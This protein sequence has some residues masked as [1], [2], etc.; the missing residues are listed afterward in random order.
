MKNIIKTKVV[1]ISFHQDVVS[2]ISPGDELFLVREDNWH[3]PNAI[4]VL[5][6]SKKQL[7]YVRRT[8]AFDVAKAMNEGVAVKCFALMI[9]GKGFSL[10]GINI[11]IQVGVSA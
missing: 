6:K 5:S 3:D 7:G 11:E 2:E 4:K 1:G 9:T 8:L 10:K